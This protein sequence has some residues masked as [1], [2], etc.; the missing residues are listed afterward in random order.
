MNHEQADKL[1]TEYLSDHWTTTPIVWPNL[2]P[3][4]FTAIGQ[5]L[6]P[7]GNKDYVA[8]RSHGTGSQTITVTGSCVRYSGQLFVSACVKEGTGV[9]LAKGYVDELVEMLENKTLKNADGAVRMGNITGPAA[10][11]APN[12]W[13][14][15]EFSIL[16]Y[17]ER[18]TH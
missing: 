7:R 2:E 3:R 4:E 10:Y 14:V 5:P 1:I 6:L 12:G 8:L 11:P 16:F 13:F 15:H 17:F 18:F 9:R